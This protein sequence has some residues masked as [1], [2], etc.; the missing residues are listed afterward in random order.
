LR[1]YETTFITDAQMPEGDI[2]AEIRKVE[3]LIRTN[4]GEIVETQRW[5]VRRLA[6]DIQKKR[7]GYY[8]HFLYKAEPGLPALVD[9]QFRINERIM[10]HLTVVSEVDL[11]ARARELAEDGYRTPAVADAPAPA[12]ETE[13]RKTE[14]EESE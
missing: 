8:A 14:R 7:Q 1:L 2:E 6:Y 3:D 12:Q 5:G 11:E 9:A 10:R 4:G 13:R